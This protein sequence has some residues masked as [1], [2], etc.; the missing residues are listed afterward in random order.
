M[1]RTFEAFHHKDAVELPQ[2][3]QETW[4]K[5]CEIVPWLSED[6][7]DLNY[8]R[9]NKFGGFEFISAGSE[10]IDIGRGHKEEIAQVHIDLEKTGEVW[11]FWV[12][13]SE[14]QTLHNN[15]P[16]T[17]PVEI[18]SIFDPKRTSEWVKKNP[19]YYGSIRHKSKRVG[20]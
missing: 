12:S 16:M 10:K 20:I 4:D 18:A 2:P 6:D 14:L 3:F 7:I 5:V 13:D 9:P 1:I 11:G 8:W 17:D 15:E 19:R